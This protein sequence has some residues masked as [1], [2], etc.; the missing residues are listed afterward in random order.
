M[1]TEIPDTSPLTSVCWAVSKAGVW[2]PVFLWMPVGSSSHHFIFM[3]LLKT[4]TQ[5]DFRLPEL[6]QKVAEPQDEYVWRQQE[7]SGGIMTVC[8]SL[9]YIPKD[10]N[11]QCT[12]WSLVHAVAHHPELA[13]HP[14]LKRTSVICNSLKEPRKH[15]AEMRQ[16]QKS[17]ACLIQLICKFKTFEI[18][19]SERRV[20]IT[21]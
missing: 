16:A 13:Y 7:S 12:F 1:N 3:V 6:L 19:V 4:L 10:V 14:E 8:L 11:V 9:Q 2:G 5:E 17:K 21:R 18:T 15:Y 20:L